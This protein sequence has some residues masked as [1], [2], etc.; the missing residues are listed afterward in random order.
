MHA[1]QCSEFDVGDRRIALLLG[2]LDHRMRNL[3]MMIDAAVRKTQSTTVDGYRA[4]LTARISSLYALYTFG[5]R[6]GR[7]RGLADLLGQTAH[8]HC[9]HDGQIL[10]A[11]PDVQLE[12]KL[13]FALQLVCHELAVNAR[14][15][16]ALSSP[17]GQV[18]IQWKVRDVA[19][20]HRK[21][22]I[23]WSEHGGPEVKRA[24]RPGFGTG[25]IRRALEGYGAVRLDF[26]P[27]GLACFMLIDLDR[28]AIPAVLVRPAADSR[29]SG[30]TRPGAMHG[31]EENVGPLF[32]DADGAQ[33]P[34]FP[35]PRG[36]TPRLVCDQTARPADPHPSIDPW[37]K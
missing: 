35:P 37:R 8:P 4:E 2:E 18:R 25:L 15:H 29:P 3:L 33:P 24:R 19:R 14:K 7:A 20:G 5:G 27:S 11:G 16:G 9:G 1:T 17:L 10:T 22:A 34:M 12:P 13:A 30:G 26:H 31:A 28:A 36:G 23:L 21:L 6:D 32:L